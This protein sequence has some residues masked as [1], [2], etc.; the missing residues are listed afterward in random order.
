MAQQ[1]C[2]HIGRGS[3]NWQTLWQHIKAKHMHTQIKKINKP[4]TCIPMTPENL[5]LSI[6]ATEIIHLY[7]HQKI[8]M[9]MFRAVLFIV[10]PD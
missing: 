3:A 9:K 6:Y 10:A 1:E 8:Q 2:S 7:V 5:L 4:N